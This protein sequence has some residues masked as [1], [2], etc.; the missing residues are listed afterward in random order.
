MADLS[1]ERIANAALEL[2]DSEGVNAFTLR[3]VARRLNVT[4]MA[5]YHHVA[6]K[7]ELAALVVDAVVKSVPRDDGNAISNRS[8]MLV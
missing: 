6:D 2:V 5:L 8:S 1:A 4:P 7:E 3:G